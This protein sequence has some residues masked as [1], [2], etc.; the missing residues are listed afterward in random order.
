VTEAEVVILNV[1]GLHAR[2]ASEFVRAASRFRSEVYL[3][4]NGLRVNGKSILGV[5]MLAAETGTRL[6]IQAHGPD[7]EQA[8]AA[9]AD[10]VN[11]RFGIEG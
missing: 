7:E 5:L 9:L 1:P 2:P 4:K 3:I 10:L 6:R 8:I 11:R